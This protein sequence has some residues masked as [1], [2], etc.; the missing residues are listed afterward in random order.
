MEDPFTGKALLS[1]SRARQTLTSV[2]MTFKSWSN[3]KPGNNA[4]YPY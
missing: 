2:H 1:D 3:Q 4:M